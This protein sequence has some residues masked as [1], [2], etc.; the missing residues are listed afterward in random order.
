MYIKKLNFAIYLVLALV[1][2]FGTSFLIGN[3]NVESDQLTGDISKASVYSKQMP[4][5]ESTIIE[6]LLRNDADY[7]EATKSDLSIIKERVEILSELTKKTIESCGKLPEFD[8]LMLPV[9]SLQ[10][11]AYNTSLAVDAATQGLEQILDGNS[12]PEYEVSSNNVYLGFDKINNQLEIG[13]SIVN[14]ANDYIENNEKAGDIASLADE[15]MQYCID[16]AVISDSEDALASWDE[17]L[18]NLQ[19]TK[20][21]E[22]SS[23][24]KSA[25]NVSKNAAN[26]S[27]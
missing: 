5:P 27:K 12:S 6:E 3:V 23:V 16:N 18:T 15:W 10:A 25:A 17:E 2:G 8:D 26:V 7:L 4:D 24:L 20:L 1:I 21:A 9:S 14:V 19:N 22:T 11:K 13:Q